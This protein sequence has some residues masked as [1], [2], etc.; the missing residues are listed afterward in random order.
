VV[1]IGELWG[2]SE[3]MAG[4]RSDWCADKSLL[5]GCCKAL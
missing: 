2:N 4:L 1:G 5:K 3:V